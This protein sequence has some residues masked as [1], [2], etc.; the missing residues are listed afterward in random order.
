MLIRF[1]GTPAQRYWYIVKAAG[2]E[3]RPEMT[4]TRYDHP[5][6]WKAD[7]RTRLVQY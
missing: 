4:E 5:D 7:V 2:R 3:T 6:D 1:A